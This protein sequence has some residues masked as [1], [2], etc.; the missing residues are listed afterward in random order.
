[1]AFS[2][3]AGGFKMLGLLEAGLAGLASA[4]LGTFIFEMLGASLFPLAGTVEPIS[5]TTGT[6]LLAQL[7]VAGFVALGAIRV[8]T[9]VLGGKWV[10]NKGNPVLD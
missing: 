3:G 5:L 2:V 1:L 4:M 9:S 8:V 7:S 6:R 10:Q